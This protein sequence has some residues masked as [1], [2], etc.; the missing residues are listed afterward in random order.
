MKTL[1]EWRRTNERLAKILETC[2]S[3]I[4]Q[5]EPE[6]EVILYGSQARG[7]AASDSD[8]DLL[9]LVPGIADWD[10]QKRIRDQL[11]DLE[12]EANL[13]LSALIIGNAVWHS[14]HHAATPLHKSIDRDGVVA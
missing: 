4:R 11:F 6:A 12:L 1:E 2:K 8:V 3:R 13:V 9:V 14:P 10:R 7:Q 5:V